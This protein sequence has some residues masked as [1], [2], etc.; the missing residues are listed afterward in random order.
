MKAI[1]YGFALFCIIQMRIGFFL[2]LVSLKVS[3]PCHV[4][5]KL[6]FFAA[7]TFSLVI[8]DTIKATGEI[9]QSI[10]AHTEHTTRILMRLS[11]TT[12]TIIATC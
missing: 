5:Q 12:V 3:S 11:V 4:S 7:I 2:S 8:R 10:Y 6:S 9:Y 1:V